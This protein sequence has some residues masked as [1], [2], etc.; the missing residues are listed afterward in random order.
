V[1]VKDF[2]DHV[3]ERSHVLAVVIAQAGA[4]CTMLPALQRSKLARPASVSVTLLL[5]LLAV[6][7]QAVA[8]QAQQKAAGQDSAPPQQDRADPYATSL[9]IVNGWVQPTI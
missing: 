8:A 2:L 4:K 3:F 9:V 6:A 5:S 1:I 7:A